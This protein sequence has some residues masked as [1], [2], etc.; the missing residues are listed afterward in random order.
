MRDM[1]RTWKSMVPGVELPDPRADYRQSAR[2]GQ[3]KVSALAL[4]QE[5]GNYLPFAGVTE[6]QRDKG[7]VH[8]TGCCIGGVPVERVVVT[9]P[10]GKRAFF[11]DSVKTADRVAGLCR[12]GAGLD[13]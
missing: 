4:Y 13:G 3:Y 12:A 6:V 2:A 5:D 8:V 1:A 11:F 9:I 10:A 7:S